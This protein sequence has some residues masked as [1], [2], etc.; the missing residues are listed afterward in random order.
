MSTIMHNGYMCDIIRKWDGG[1][2]DLIT[3][4]PTEKGFIETFLSVHWSELIE[5]GNKL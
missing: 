5:E 2:Y 3:V 4:H 1:Y